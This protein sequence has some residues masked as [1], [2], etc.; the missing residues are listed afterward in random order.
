MK[1]NSL[2][3]CGVRT[4]LKVTEGVNV[5]TDALLPAF[6][7]FPVIS[8]PLV[9]LSVV[10]PLTWIYHHNTCFPSSNQP[11][12]PPT[13]SFSRTHSIN[14][15]VNLFGTMYFPATSRL[16]DS[17]DFK[18]FPPPGHFLLWKATF[19]LFFFVCDLI[20]APGNST[21]ELFA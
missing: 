18:L 21:A 19:C 16:R 7:E 3:C 4:R 11:V 6:R 10:L 5:T 1:Q 12:Q 8:P 14:L 13:R 9:C 17:L 2:V 20:P 15:K